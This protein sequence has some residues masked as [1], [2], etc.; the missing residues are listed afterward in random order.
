MRFRKRRCIDIPYSAF[1]DGK[2][3]M[4][5]G[6][7][8]CTSDGRLGMAIR[9]MGGNLFGALAVHDRTEEQRP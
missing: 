1:I 5:G 7:Y 3:Y 9:E 2:R 6:N 8:A 4:F